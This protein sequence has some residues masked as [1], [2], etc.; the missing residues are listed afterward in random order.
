MIKLLVVWD[1]VKNRV[2][3]CSDHI[4]GQR[5]PYALVVFK[6]LGS[7]H[8]HKRSKYTTKFFIRFVSCVG[9]F[10]IVPPQG[11]EAILNAILQL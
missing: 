11:W 9:L 7:R 6:R 5:H 10:G 1:V 2:V 8:I 4:K 3:W